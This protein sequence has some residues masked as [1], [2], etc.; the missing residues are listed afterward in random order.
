MVTE[1]GFIYNWLICVCVFFSIEW[2]LRYII[3]RGSGFTDNCG[4][5]TVQSIKVY[6]NE[7]VY[8]RAI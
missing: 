5:V 6:I 4:R 8:K 7:Y 3:L 1:S 2:A